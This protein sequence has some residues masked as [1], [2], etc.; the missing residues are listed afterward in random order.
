MDGKVRQALGEFHLNNRRGH[1][2]GRPYLSSYQIAIAIE[3]AHPGLC[4]RI[5]KTIG[6]R[7]TGEHH[8]LP[9]YISNEL[10]RQVRAQGAQH[11]AEGVFLTNKDVGQLDYVGPDDAAVSSSLGPDVALFRLRT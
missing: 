9:Q 10:S 8:S 1:H 4:Q 3:R 5:G 7:G 6:G 11:Y 2:L